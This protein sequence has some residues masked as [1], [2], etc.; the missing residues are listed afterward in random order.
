MTLWLF[1]D[2]YTQFNN[3][4]NQW[5]FT[6]SNILKT[7]LNSLALHGTALEFTYQRFNIARKKIKEN[8][9]VI[10][11]LPNFDRRWFFASYPE[12]AE[13]D[14]SP[15]NNKKE[16]KAIS[17]FREY[18]DH[19]EIHQVYLIDFLYNLYSLTEDLNLHTII[20]PDSDDVET[21]LNEKKELFPLFH[22]PIGKFEDI[23]D[24]NIDKNLNYLKDE[25]HT[26]LANKIIDNIKN[27]TI[28]N[29]KEEF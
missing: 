7:D 10:V 2:I 26:I 14:S 28:I 11:S 22:I 5:M 23:A 9:I 19:K 13:F 3:I 15:T 18:L 29:F 27:N 4:S 16:N 8:D 12:Y 24:K 6:V 17:L 20:I 21:F 1:G 25:S